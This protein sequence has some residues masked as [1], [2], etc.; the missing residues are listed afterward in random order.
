M[1]DELNKSK[2][3]RVLLKQRRSLPYNQWRQKSDRIVS[4]LQ[5]LS[6]FQSAQTI[7]A[8]F[9]FHQEPDLSPLFTTNRL[10]GFPRVEGKSLM[11]HFWQQGDKLETNRYGIEQPPADAPMVP[12]N[13][14]DLILVPAVACDKR[15]YRLGYGGGF[16]DRML[17]QSQ[18]FSPTTIGIVFD[19][20]YLP[21][22]SVDPWDKKLD[23][24]CTDI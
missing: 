23:F 24:I 5:T 17:N 2:L 21:Q 4:H 8:Y 9:S 22:L 15:G 20:A 7:L 14:V 13:S 18:W 3:R 10:W 6:S 16:Y 11:W 1:H 12:P 19:F